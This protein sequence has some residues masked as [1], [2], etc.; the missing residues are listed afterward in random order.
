[1]N[2]CSRTRL[3]QCFILICCDFKV[4]TTCNKYLC[5]SGQR[6][7]S[8]DD[9]PYCADCFGELFSKRCTSCAKPITGNIGIVRISSCAHGVSQSDKT[10]FLCQPNCF[11]VMVLLASVFI[12]V[13]TCL[14][15]L[16]FSKNCEFYQQ[17][18]ISVIRI[19]RISLN[20]DVT[21]W[22]DRLPAFIYQSIFQSIFLSNLYLLS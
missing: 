17:G 9:K 7:T 12:L 16:W 21:A 20:L 4:V 1:M 6:F 15:Y 5:A 19:V 8:R 3:L 13:L 14:E 10:L 11:S 22:N 18:E 2:T